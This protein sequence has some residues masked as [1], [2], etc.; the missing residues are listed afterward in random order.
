MIQSR[1]WNP[2]TV[3]MCI[4]AILFLAL[5]AI[6]ASYTRNDFVLPFDGARCLIHGCNPYGG[7]ELLYPPSTLLVLSPLALFQ[8]PAAWLTWFLL[9]GALLIFATFLILSL[10]PNPHRWLATSLGAILLAGSSR[11]LI[12][13][14][15]SAFAISLVV[16][17]VYCFLRGRR[18]LVGTVLLM[19]SLAVKPFIGGLIVFYLFFKGVHRRYAALAMSGALSI[20][21]CAGLILKMRP[22]STNWVSDIRANISRAVAPGGTDDPRP[23]SEQAVAALNLQTVTSVFFR[24]EKQFNVA[25]Y[26]VFTVLFLAWALVTLRMDSSIENHL[27]AIGALTVITLLPI[28]HRTYDSRFLV[29][30]IPS[31]VIIF[32]GCRVIGAF[33]CALIALAT[34]ST[35]HLAQELLLRDGLLQTIRQSKVL[36]IFLLRGSDVQLLALFGLFMV[37]FLK[38]YNPMK[39]AATS[40]PAQDYSKLAYN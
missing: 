19:L 25:A 5:S 35:Q 14:Q 7:G 13:A 36:L 1:K 18:I 2:H 6:R 21:L 27:L 3:V 9:N 12:L 11:L 37:A 29:L 4:A 16:I 39:A 34:V 15:P 28:Y 31:A 38:I 17:G 8:Y 40:S 10:C 30:C 23:A 33:M 26:A 20:L 24:E 22:E 32:E